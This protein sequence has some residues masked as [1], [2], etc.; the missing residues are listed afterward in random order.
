[1]RNRTG[2]YVAGALPALA[3][4]VGMILGWLL[5]Y[6]G[7]EGQAA[8][9]AQVPPLVNPAFEGAFPRYN[10]VGELQVAEGWQPWYAEDPG[11]LVYRPEYKPELRSVG[12]GR[13]HT[14]EKAQ[15]LFTTYARHD[16]GIYQVVEGTVPGQWYTFQVWAWQWSSQQD[17]PNRSANDG[18]CSVMAGIN[19]WGDERP[20]YRTTIWGQEALQVYDQWVQVGVTAQAWS[21]HIVVI[22]RQTAEWPVKHVDAYLDDA[23]LYL[24]SGPGVLPTY[25]PR[26]TYTLQPTYTPQPPC[27][28][29]P[30]YT[31]YPTYTPAPTCA[32]E[33]GAV[34]YEHMRSVMETVVA[35]RDPV[36]WP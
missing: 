15:K 30:T 24:S 16:G 8:A 5:L 9:V 32:A 3:V 29:Q 18:K 19:P 2:L 14:G 1:M 31:P 13:V 35:G 7:T 6:N 21:T 17:D 28:R 20:L 11:H 23:A 4:A 33:Q 27:T 26:P 25:T 10:D 22:V 12:A 34:D 36:R